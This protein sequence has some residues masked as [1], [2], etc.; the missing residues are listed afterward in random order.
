LTGPRDFRGFGAYL[1]IMGIPI[2][3]VAGAAVIAAAI[4]VTN[5]WQLVPTRESLVALRLNRWT[6]LIEVCMY[7]LG[8]QRDPKSLAGVELACRAK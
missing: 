5:H 1:P 6:G 3:I 2:A 7:D 8:T 4:L